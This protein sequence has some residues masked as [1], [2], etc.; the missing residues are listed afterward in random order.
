MMAWMIDFDSIRSQVTEYQRCVREGEDAG[1]AF[2]DDPADLVAALLAEAD[3]ST[4]AKRLGS[5]LIA[6]A[7]SQGSDDS[8][9]EWYVNALEKDAVAS[10]LEAECIRGRSS[11]W[12]EVAGAVAEPL[13]VAADKLLT[14]GPER[15]MA[16]LRERLEVM[17][18]READL[19][20]LWR[21]INIEDLLPDETAGDG[22]MQIIR[23]LR[24]AKEGSASVT[25]PPAVAVASGTHLGALGFAPPATSGNKYHRTVY[26]ITP[27]SPGSPGSVTIDVYSV[28]IAFDVRDPG[29][30]HAAKKILCAG[31]RGKASR[32]QDLREARDALD[33]AIQEAERAEKGGA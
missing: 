10:R 20:S 2:R 13:H 29:L 11:L 16:L 19:A 26:D 6:I 22:V 4:A 32:S 24:R 1:F 30:Q 28:L 21:I 18:A 3:R 23:T 25:P 8:E 14:A 12:A 17:S 27:G 31:C 33:R 9:I 5:S 7:K 15:G